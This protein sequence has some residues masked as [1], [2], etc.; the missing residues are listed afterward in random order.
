LAGEVGFIQLGDISGIELTRQLA[1]DGFKYPIVF[2][3]AL[4]GA[5]VRRVARA[6]V[7]RGGGYCVARAGVYRGVYRRL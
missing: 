6:G 5:A 2:I 7:Y 3:S 4:D 1:D